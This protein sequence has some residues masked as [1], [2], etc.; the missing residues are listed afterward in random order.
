[1]KILSNI[2]STWS[3]VQLKMEIDHTNQRKSTTN[4]LVKQR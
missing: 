1:M 3:L 4:P 2:P